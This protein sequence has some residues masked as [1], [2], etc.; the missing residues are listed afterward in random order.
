MSF[1]VKSLISE[2]MIEEMSYVHCC[3]DYYS[4]LHMQ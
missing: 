4:I 1:V 2:E 3:G